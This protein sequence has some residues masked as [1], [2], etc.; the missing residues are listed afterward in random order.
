[1]IQNAHNYSF[2]LY[3]LQN[4]WQ[5]VVFR[6][7]GVE[8]YWSFSFQGWGLHQGVDAIQQSLL[9]AA[10]QKKLGLIQPH[11]GK[12]MTCF[13]FL[14]GISLIKICAMQSVAA[15]DLKHTWIRFCNWVHWV[16]KLEIRSEFGLLK[17]SIWF[18]YE[19]G[20][21]VLPSW[22]NEWSD[23]GRANSIH[24]HPVRVEYGSFLETATSG[25][26]YDTQCEINVVQWE[27][28][29]YPTSSPPSSNSSSVPHPKSNI[30]KA[31]SYSLPPLLCCF[32]RVETDTHKPGEKKEKESVVRN[33]LNRLLPSPYRTLC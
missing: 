33:G 8:T 21:H 14:I 7:R 16:Q 26:R 32:I 28:A 13:W 2:C 20:P 29:S 9:R 30:L 4:Q 10:A 17:L 31:L 27:A 23:W 1:M 19:G 18:S 24:W 15:L 12:V 11:R 3:F 22:M 6:G 5:V 25:G